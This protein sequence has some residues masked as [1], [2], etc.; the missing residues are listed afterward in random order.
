MLTPLLV[1]CMVS[2]GVW[3]TTAIREERQV[4]LDNSYPTVLYINTALDSA[5]ANTRADTSNVIHV[6]LY[7]PNQKPAEP[8]RAVVVLRGEAEGTLVLTQEDPPAGVTRIEGSISN[9]T[10]GLHG[11]HI[12]QFGDLSGGC[13][14]AGG[15]YNPF[16]KQHG[17]PENFNRHLG[18]L[19]NIV[20][21][22]SGVAFVN[23]TD[24]LVA[25]TGLR[26]VVGRAVVVHAGAD[27]LGK[28]GNEES[29]KTGNAGGRVACGVIGF[30]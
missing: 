10:S 7:P 12:H 13:G 5:S 30:A 1:L 25:L 20:A 2:V 28:G 11:F 19:G 22:E 4:V 29:L 23:I 15:H 8:R 24:P 17:A 9:L 21:D 18:D 3:A 14:T 27:D 6:N 26:T 16:G